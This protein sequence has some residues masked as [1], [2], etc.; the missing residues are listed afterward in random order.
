MHGDW[1]NFEA[2][3]YIVTVIHE[4]V[5]FV[6][7]CSVLSSVKTTAPDTQVLSKQSLHNEALL[8]EC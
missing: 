7:F 3:L 4:V 8:D 5:H 1:L 2:S 6:G